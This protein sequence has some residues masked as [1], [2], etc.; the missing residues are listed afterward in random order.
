[1]NER[2]SA[3]RIARFV[4]ALLWGSAVLIGYY[5]VH[6]PVSLPLAAALGRALLDLF[7]AL[8]L[9][10]LAGGAGRRLLPA[11]ELTP[12]ERFAIQA[13]LGWGLF[14]LLWLGLGL[15]GL[16]SSWTAWALLVIGWALLRRENLGWLNELHAV[17]H[18]WNRAG[19]FGKA[20]ALGNLA[21]VGGQ[22]LFALAPPFKWD[23]LMYHLEL[24]RRYLQAGRFLFLDGNP[25]WGHPQLGE[26]LYTWAMALRGWETAGALGWCFVAVLLLG[27]W[28]TTARRAGA[29]S[30]CLAVTALLVGLSFRGMLSWAYV[31]GL[32]AL[33]G[34]AVL[35]ALLSMLDNRPRHWCR[36][37][38]CFVGFALG[39][40]LTAGI[41]LPIVMLAPILSRKQSASKWWLHLL[42]AGAI[43]LVVFL[44]WLLKNAMFTGNPLYP[45]IWQTDW[46][47]QDR[48]AYYRGAGEALGWQSVWLPVAATW[49][50]VEGSAGFA[51]DI[52]PLLALFALPGVIARWR[53]R[54]GRLVA[55]WVL[56]QTRL[57]FILLPPVALAAGWGWEA[58]R[59]I[60]VLGARLGRV[61]GVLVIL[62]LALSLWQDA[63]S[64][65]RLNPAAVLLGTRSSEQYLDDSLGWYAPAMRALHDL[66]RE[67]S[68]L[69]LWEPRGLYAPPQ[70]EADVWIDRWY[71]DRR[72]IGD[73]Q[74]ILESWRAEDYTHLLVCR[75]GADFE[76][77]HRAK[78]TSADW[79]ALDDLLSRLSLPT[80]FGG[81][82][83]LYSLS[84]SR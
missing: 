80:D 46:M 35:I 17:K 43:S 64:L 19:R 59:G 12:L 83:R 27:V 18:L 21:L 3:P 47:S 72:T 38:A 23:T 58:M 55:L 42:E 49:L 54:D 66:P 29:T 30:G 74:A 2:P 75:S 9:T 70:A 1:V 82:Y 79:Q 52:G 53:A 14:G 37:A 32:A 25:Y 71:L 76:R 6:K 56:W 81:V 48:L 40:K 63:V 67:S 26:M 60:V 44:P 62:V 50:G 11:R 45:H 10:G 77:Q 22:L 13:A 61:I 68:P 51:A 28:G 78:L 34:C 73:P 65:A 8:A 84:E 15:L 24:P 5:Y 31:D 36:W 20:L 16:Y 33:Y 57:Y 39:I 69:L 41:L 7:A 4:I